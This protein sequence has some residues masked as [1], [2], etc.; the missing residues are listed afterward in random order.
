MN[1]SNDKLELFLNAISEDLNALR[2]NIE[3]E[4]ADRQE[5]E[6]QIACEEA[7]AMSTEYLETEKRKVRL[8]INSS[9][10]ALETELK[11]E[12]A[13][14]RD[15]IT[16]EVFAE[17]AENIA[18][19]TQTP[20]YELFLTKSLMNIA[21]IYGRNPITVFARPSDLQQ[22]KGL[23]HCLPVN[24]ELKTDTG[25]ILGGLKA[26]CSEMSLRLD[27]TLDSRLKMQKQYFYENSGLTIQPD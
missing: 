3:Q 14:A 9:R 27:D 4:T 19:F 21:G 24:S 25:I 13:A 22:V 1:T 8:Q 15:S 2:R 18:A 23:L 11:H 26:L 16:D 17:A 5:K 20:E 10:C 7:Y 6:L 12:F